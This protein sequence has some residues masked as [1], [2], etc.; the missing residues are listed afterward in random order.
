MLKAVDLHVLLNNLLA[1]TEKAG[2]VF[3]GTF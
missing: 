3:G 2:N 1:F